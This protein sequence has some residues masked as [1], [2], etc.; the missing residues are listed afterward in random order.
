M[1]FTR[2]IRTRHLPHNAWGNR[3]F[4]RRKFVRIHGR[5]PPA[6]QPN[7]L[8]DYIYRIKVDGTLTDP[9]RQFVTDKEFAKLYIENAVGP[10][11]LIP[12]PISL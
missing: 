9:L 5:P 10:D 3:E 12:I 4:W 8:T 7:R 2:L 1:N 6:N 11:Y